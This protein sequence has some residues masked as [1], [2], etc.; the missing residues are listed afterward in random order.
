MNSYE[1]LG[2]SM[3]Y[4]SELRIRRN[5]LPDF[6]FSALELVAR[7]RLNNEI[8]RVLSVKTKALNKCRKDFRINN[9]DCVSIDS[10][11]GIDGA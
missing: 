3:V 1:E 8:A 11:R 10:T 7:E 5:N 9:L 6:P 4:L 2:R